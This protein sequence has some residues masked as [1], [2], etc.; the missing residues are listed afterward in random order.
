MIVLVV[1][2]IIFSSADASSSGSSSLYGYAFMIGGVIF[3]SFT[4]NFEKKNI[5]AKYKAT[6]CETMFFASMFGFI[7][8]VGFLLTTDSEHFF[9]ALTFFATTPSVEYCPSSRCFSD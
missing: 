3:D 2:I 4:S 8:S 6:H 1:G 9:E 7:W 5:F